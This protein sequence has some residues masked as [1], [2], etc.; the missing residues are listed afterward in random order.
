LDDFGHPT[1]ALDRFG[2]CSWNF[3]LD[4]SEF[5]GLTSGYNVSEFDYPVS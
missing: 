3:I 5:D 4:K 1:D 2:K